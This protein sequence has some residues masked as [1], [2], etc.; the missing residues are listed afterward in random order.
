MKRHQILL[1][2]DNYLV[3]LKTQNTGSQNGHSFHSQ[4]DIKHIIFK[5]NVS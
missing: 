3:I 1:F 5:L 4:A 2:K